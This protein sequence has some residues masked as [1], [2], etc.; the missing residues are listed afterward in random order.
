[1]QTMPLQNKKNEIV[2]MVKLYLYVLSFAKEKMYNL[3][4]KRI[5]NDIFLGVYMS[6]Y[7][8]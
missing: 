3:K 5:P 8:M 1:M 2:P 6:T 4:D 7:F